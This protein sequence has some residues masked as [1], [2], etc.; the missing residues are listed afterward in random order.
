[1]RQMRHHRRQQCGS[2]MIRGGRRGARM[3]LTGGIIAYLVLAALAVRWLPDQPFAAAV[4]IFFA[5]HSAAHLAVEE[6]RSPR[7]QGVHRGRTWWHSS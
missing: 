7:R 6:T 4:F 2:P 5:A 1:M 3:A